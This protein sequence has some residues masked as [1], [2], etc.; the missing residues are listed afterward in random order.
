MPVGDKAGLR[1]Q[2]R[3][4][5]SGPTGQSRPTAASWHPLIAIVKDCAGNKLLNLMVKCAAD[6]VG[7]D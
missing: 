4:C 6:L 5:G 2:N 7:F 3:D 1:R